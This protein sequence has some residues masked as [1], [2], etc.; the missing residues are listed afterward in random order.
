MKKKATINQTIKIA[1]A[2][3]GESLHWVDNLSYEEAD[4]LIKRL[5]KKRKRFVSIGAI[6]ALSIVLLICLGAW[7]FKKSEKVEEPQNIPSFYP[8]RRVETKPKVY[9]PPKEVPAKKVSSKSEKN[10]EKKKLY[11]Y[12]KRQLE[13]A[14]MNVLNIVKAAYPDAS[15]TISQISSKD[16][17]IPLTL[18]GHVIYKNELEP[19][20]A[21]FCFPG[22]DKWKAKIAVDEYIIYNNM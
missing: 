1:K 11:P 4:A 6:V 2:L 21:K 14:S 12:S 19:L 7:Y 13:T 20:E 17:S 18:S 22:R 8:Y 3:G 16:N 5:P 10:I 15:I 9:T